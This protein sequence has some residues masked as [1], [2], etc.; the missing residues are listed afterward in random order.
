M[1]GLS[2]GMLANTDSLAAPNPSR[3]AVLCAASTSLS[4]TKFTASMLVPAA[5]LATFTLE[6]TRSVSLST[7]GMDRMSASSAGVIPFCTSAVKPPTRSTPTSRTISSRAQAVWKN[8]SSPPPPARAL[9]AVTAMRLFTTGM[10]YLLPTSSQALTRSRA[11]SRIF[12]CTLRHSWA[13][14]GSVQSSRLMPSVTVRT[15]RCSSWNMR[16]VDTMSSVLSI[17][18][19][20]ARVY[21]GLWRNSTSLVARNTFSCWRLTFISPGG[22]SEPTSIWSRS[23]SSSWGT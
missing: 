9:T 14:S 15:S 12:S 17:G 6:Q 19:A 1:N 21:D 3:S 4:A 22:Q 18:R 13:T 20:L 10:P 16:R 8:A 7:L 5:V 23:T 2:S 11:F